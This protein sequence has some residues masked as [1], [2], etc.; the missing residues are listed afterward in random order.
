MMDQ[1]Q[2]KTVQKLPTTTQ[3]TRSP[4]QDRLSHQDI[5]KKQKQHKKKELR[6]IQIKQMEEQLA[7]ERKKREE[8]NEEIKSLINNTAQ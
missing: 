4:S 6:K 2:P 7:K 5:Y 8:I 1:N 3:L